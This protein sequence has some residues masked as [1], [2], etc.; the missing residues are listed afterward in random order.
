MLIR[1]SDLTKKYGLKLTGVLHIGAHQC[2][3]RDWYHEEGVTDANII[4]L[5]GNE[6]LVDRQRAKDPAVQIFEALVSNKDGEPINFIVTNNGQSSSILELGTH[7]Q[8]YP[9]VVE[10]QRIASK[11]I[12]VDTFLMA[13]RELKHIVPKLNFLN[14]DIQGAELK[15]L[16]GMTSL[17]PQFQALYLEVNTAE[18]YEGCALLPELDAFLAS[19]HFRRVEI[20]MTG[21]SWGDA[22]YLR[23]D[24]P[25]LQSASVSNSASSSSASAS[26]APA[27]TR[28][29]FDVGANIGAWALA[30]KGLDPSANIVCVEA[31]PVTFKILEQHV[32]QQSGIRLVLGCVSS[33]KDA[34]VPFYHC[35]NETV[36]S[37]TDLDWLRSE[38]SRFGS[39]SNQIQT[40]SVPVVSLDTLIAQCGVPDLLKVDVEGAEAKVLASLT[41]KVPIL[42]FEWAA[43]W[44]HSY[45]ECIDILNKLG[46]T[47][48]HVQNG[49]AYTYVP[50]QFELTC[51]QAREFLNKQIPKE[52]WGMC[53][54]R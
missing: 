49:N 5:E 22:M 17:L 45:N 34:R 32:R 3:E 19:H 16:Q 38:K 13:H 20:A 51:E 40:F 37:T 42:C 36:I 21:E 48:F 52:A 39:V 44:S 29:I 25:M 11:T 23:D 1:L 31:S 8:H 26:A 41:Q 9:D 47:E 7:K 53:W 18:V 46:F 30:Q 10:T 54:A 35:L 27:K 50:P 6:A 43:E 24:H 2:E 33:S 28:L 12:T 15:A 4:W 14:I